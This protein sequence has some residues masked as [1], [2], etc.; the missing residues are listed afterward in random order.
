[1]NEKIS[2][3]GSVSADDNSG[4]NG[5]PVDT[6]KI[7]IGKKEIWVIGEKDSAKTKHRKSTKPIWAG[8]ELGINS[9]VDGGGNFNLNPGNDAFELKTEKSVSFSLNLFQKNFEIA[10]S[11]VWFFTGLGITWNNYRF[12]NNYLLNP[13]TPVSMSIDTTSNIN[14]KKSKLVVSNLTVPLMFEAF[15]SRNSKKAF[16]IG[17]GA[18][19]G[20]R[21][22][23]HTKQ[24]FEEGGKVSKPKVY[25]DFNL[26]PFRYGVRVAVGYHKFNVFA[27]YYASALFKDQ[28]GPELY[29][30][31]FGFTLVGF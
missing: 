20:L 2:G 24:K 4:G 19:L 13:T 10:K 27:D 7:N 11:N 18:L 31:N 16:H 21:L 14:Y 6:T 1:L 26:N 12:E 15:T 29:P 5:S 30:V 23:S 25:D 8:L 3:N 28:K 17:A 22:G 9:Y